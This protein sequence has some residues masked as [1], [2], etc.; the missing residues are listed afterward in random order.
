LN[1]ARTSPTRVEPQEPWSV[2]THDPVSSAHAIECATL[3]LDPSST[4]PGEREAGA[5]RRLGLRGALLRRGHPRVVSTKI[6]SFVRRDAQPAPLLE[7][8]GVSPTLST[9]R[10]RLSWFRR[11]SSGE[12]RARVETRCFAIQSANDGC[13]IRH[14]L[15]LHR[16]TG[17]PRSRIFRY[18]REATL[19][20]SARW[21]PRRSSRLSFTMHGE[22][23][24]RRAKLAR[25]VSRSQSF[26]V[27]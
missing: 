27:R 16:I 19:G 1:K 9:W 8:R 3:S 5:R 12:G 17:E 6:A 18:E 21:M 26:V 23:K 7:G 15:G 10:P 14:P 24:S 25:T 13:E 2:R 20:E 11:A 4:S 22:P